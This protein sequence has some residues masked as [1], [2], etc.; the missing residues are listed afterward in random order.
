MQKESSNC[1]VRKGKGDSRLLHLVSGRDRQPLLIAKKCP[2]PCPMEVPA[3]FSKRKRRDNPASLNRRE[4]YIHK[5]MNASDFFDFCLKKLFNT[6]ERRR[7]QEIGYFGSGMYQFLYIGMVSEE[8]LHSTSDS[9]IS[10]HAAWNPSI[11]L[12]LLIE[13]AFWRYLARTLTILGKCYSRRTKTN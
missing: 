8:I 4:S 2:E 6:R 10:R 5:K 12:S 1:S 3:P 9:S 13:A 11:N 7:L